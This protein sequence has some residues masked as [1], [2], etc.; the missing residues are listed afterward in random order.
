MNSD[1]DDLV[2][3]ENIKPDEST[4]ENIANEVSNIDTTEND[5]V[6]KATDDVNN[7]EANL[8]SADVEEDS[9]IL[10][11]N[12]LQD[13]VNVEDKTLKEKESS[14]TIIVNEVVNEEDVSVV[15]TLCETVNKIDDSVVAAE[16]TVYATVNFDHSPQDVLST[17]D[18]KTVEG[19]VNRHEHLQRNIKKL[20]FG[21]YDTGRVS[22]GYH[23][24][25]SLKLYVDTSCLWNNPR[26]YIWKFCGQDEWKMGNGTMVTINRI[27]MK[28]N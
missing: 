26:T 10:K 15:E 6:A 17:N 19:I 20:E 21:S 27:H 13:K 3:I 4:I 25:L 7:S 5:V 14:D 23:H 16:V 24:C 1:N 8:D 12:D 22:D 28:Q 11:N 9:S 18:F 2:C